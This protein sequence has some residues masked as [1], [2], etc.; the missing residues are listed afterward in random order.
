MNITSN[1]PTEEFDAGLSAQY[2]IDASEGFEIEGFVSGPLSDRIRGRAVINYRDVDGWVEN[3][4]TGEDLQKSEDLTGRVILDFDVTDN[5][6]AEV[7]YQRTDFNREGKARG[8]LPAV[9]R[10]PH[11]PV[12]PI[13]QRGASALGFDCNGIDAENSTADIRRNAP[14]GATFNSGEPFDLESDLVGL[15]LTAEYDNFVITS[16]TSWTGYQITDFFSGDQASFERVAINN[17]EDYEQIYQELRINGS[18]D[19]GLFDYIAGITYFSGELDAT[20]SFHAVDR[21]IGPPIPPNVAISRNEFQQSETSS[22]AAFGQI[23]WHINEQF[24][25]IGGLRVTDEDRDGAKQQLVG[26]VYTSDVTASPTPCNTPFSP[27]SACTNGN[28]GLTTG[29][30]VTGEIS[31]TNVSYNVSLQYAMND[32]HKFLFHPCNRF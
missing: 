24:T 30:P 3:S 29:D 32:D 8:R 21:A 28:D 20:Q 22:I 19:S 4:V 5:I 10:S 7:M 16:L 31:K 12:R 13:P 1:K 2:N 6:T 9:W 18:S 15:T 14:G 17:F 27:L 11:L 23:D 25:L 26:E